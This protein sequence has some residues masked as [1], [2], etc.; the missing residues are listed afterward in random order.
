MIGS[1]FYTHAQKRNHTKLRKRRLVPSEEVTDCDWERDREIIC[2]C[3]SIVVILVAIATVRRSGGA[4]LSFMVSERLERRSRN[5]Q[6]EVSTSLNCL[7][8]VCVCVCVY[9]CVCV[10]VRLSASQCALDSVHY[11]GHVWICSLKFH[12]SHLITPVSLGFR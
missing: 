11:F 9:V 7:V 8:E 5:L 12:L 1:K 10:C 4:Y 3:W 2:C 6:S